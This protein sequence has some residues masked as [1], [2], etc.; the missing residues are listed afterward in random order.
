[1]DSARFPLTQT[2]LEA[3][4][5]SE[6]SHATFA[7][8]RVS[9]LADWLYTSG[10]RRSDFQ[11]AA[12]EKTLRWEIR[13][14]GN[15]GR[16]WPE[17]DI[18]YSSLFRDFRNP[19]FGE[20]VQAPPPWLVESIAGVRARRQTA[21]QHLTFNFMWQEHLHTLAIF[22]PKDDSGLKDKMLS[23]TQLTTV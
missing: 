13:K 6:D 12:K 5:F 10:A 3:R 16:C 18:L 1:M 2:K 9:R 8:P 7:L 4:D 19:Q 11:S 21:I 22:R 14:L 15:G 20:R 23:N 17:R